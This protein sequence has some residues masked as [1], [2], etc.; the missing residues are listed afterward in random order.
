MKNKNGEAKE[1][2]IVDYVDATGERHIQTFS[3]K[4]NA[5]EYH[6]TVRVDVRRRAHAEKQEQERRGGG[7]GL[8]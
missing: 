5:D 1:A 6:A 8:D 2:W 3:G 4:K 7:Q